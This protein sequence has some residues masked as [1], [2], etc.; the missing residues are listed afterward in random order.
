MKIEALSASVPVSS[1][2]IEQDA[3]IRGRTGKAFDAVLHEARAGTAWENI[4]SPQA[5]QDLL[6]L[7]SKISKSKSISARE[8]IEYQVKASQFGLGIE[9]VSKV[10][11]SV[12]ASLR[13]FQTNQ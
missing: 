1:Q 3:G 5:F 11:E 4:A 12:S 6:S 9:L 13:K 2:K 10:A 8:L 7:Q